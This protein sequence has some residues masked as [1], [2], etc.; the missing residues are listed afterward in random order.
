MRVLVAV[1]VLFCGL[2]TQAHAFLGSNCEIY[3][4]AY[5]ISSSDASG[6]LAPLADSASKDPD[7]VPGTERN[8]DRKLLLALTLT[9][10]EDHYLYG[11]ESTDGLPTTME[12]AYA[13]L[14]AFPMTRM[15]AGEISALL[16]EKGSPLPVR[17]PQPV[18]KKDSPFAQLR[19]PGSEDSNPHIYPGPITF[20]TVA[21]AD[22]PGLGGLALQVR[23]SGLLCSANSCTPASGEL[24][25]AFSA[26]ELAAFPP[27]EQEDW[28]TALR[29]GEDVLIPV[30]E[31]VSEDAFFPREDPTPFHSASPKTDSQAENEELARQTAVFA[32]LEPGFFNPDV[33]VQYLGEALFFGLLAGLLLNLMPC[34]LPVVS[35]KFS[36][37]MAVSSMTDKTQQAKAFR[38]HCCIFA[39]GIMAWF[40]ILALMLGVAGW[41]WGELFQQPLV[42][43]L[44]GFIL[45]MLGLS[46]FGVFPLP[47]F[48]LKVTSDSHPHWQA[49]ASGLLATLLAT[50]CSGPLLGGVL[51]WAI[52]QPLPVLVLTVASVGGGMSLPYCVMA[53]CPRLV[54]L[55]PRP[56]AWTLRLE[57]LL[58]FFLMGSVVYL[59]TLLPMEWIPAFL[60]NLFAIAFAAWLWGQ[61][62]HLRASRL[63][64]GI[65]RCLAVAV[66]LLAVFWGKHSIKIDNTWEIFEPQAFI[67]MLGKEPIL[68]EFTADWCPSCKALE[69][70][71]LNKKRM[72]DLRRRYNIR[73]IRVDLTRNADA[74]NELLKALNSTSIPVLALFP[75]GENSRQ[76]VVLR[77]LVTPAQ[78]EAAAS[79]TFSRKDFDPLRRVLSQKKTAPDNMAP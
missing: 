29:E 66:V 58:G 36:A 9:P 35:L 22:V 41:A 70:T 26:K 56:G 65:A 20:W 54:H 7:D 34:V 1:I 51:A 39:L 72:A 48:D 77:D 55:L 30:P 11:P 46:L 27:A 60:F 2:A 16:D 78:L 8:D 10:P 42:I 59:A 76:P 5:T 75:E 40:L 43:V 73:T 31:G 67:E 38:V 37:L 14:D 33:E 63:R 62:G 64:R 13:V 50:P 53:F 18:L 25:L 52:R 61:I 3:W 12:A 45:F 24:N 57:Q 49:F 68:M 79:A 69:Y 6:V 4:K 47:I 44:L 71:T 74:G 23:M 28:F 15:Q 19:L 21:P 17:V 32:T